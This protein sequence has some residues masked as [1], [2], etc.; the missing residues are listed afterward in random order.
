MKMKKFAAAAM[1]LAL[2]GGSAP[3]IGEFSPSSSLIASAADT[4]YVDLY[5]SL[6]TVSATRATAYTCDK[7]AT[8]NMS[9]RTYYQGIVFDV[10]YSGQKS[11]ITFDV[12]G[13]NTLSW[14]NGHIDGSNKEN[15][16]LKVYVDDNLEDS[17]QLTWTMIA[18]K[19][20]LD[21]SKA[22]KVTL[23]LD[24]CSSCKYGIGDVTTDTDSPSITSAKVDYKNVS[25][26]IA[27]YFDSKNITAYQG[28][29]KSEGFNMNGRTYYQGYYLDGPYSGNDATLSL[30]VE[31]LSKV[32]WTVGHI[33]NTDRGSAKLNVYVDDELTES[34]KLT[35][36]MEL[37][38]CEITLP[39]DAKEM[40]IELAVDQSGEYGIGDIKADALDA[41]V[42]HT[43]PDF[44][45]SSTFVDSGYDI[46][47]A[48]KYT[49]SAKGTNY[50]VNGR[51]Y[52]QGIVF[53]APYSNY[54]TT[55]SY[56]VENLS[57][58][59]FTVGRVANSGASSA[60]L[61]IYIDNVEFD[62][63]A[64]S[65]YMTILPYE[66]KVADAKNVRFS[67]TANGECAY[68]LME[69]TADALAPELIYTSP[70]YAK[71]NNLTDSFFNTSGY[72]AYA[73]NTKADSFNMN[74]RTYYEGIVFE[75]SYSGYNSGASVNVENVD[76]FSF[77]L[78]HVDGTG[79]SAANLNVYL[80]DE[81]IDKIALKGGMILDDKSYD[82]SKGTVL[83]FEVTDRKGGCSYALGDIKADDKETA[84]AHVV[85]KY[86]D[87]KSFIEA[88]FDTYAVKTFNGSSPKVNFFTMGGVDY[89]TGLVFDSSASNYT[90]YISFNV[91]NTDALSFL[92]GYVDDSKR[93]GYKCGATV[94]IYKD[95]ELYQTVKLGEESAPEV[96]NIDTKDAQYIE[97]EVNYDGYGQF[98]VGNISFTEGVPS[99]TTTTTSGTTE[100]TTTTTTTK[101]ADS[102][103]AGRLFGDING[104][105]I[106]DGRD[107]TEMLT[108]YAKTSTGYKGTIEDYMRELAN[109]SAGASSTPAATSAPSTTTTAKATEAPKAT[110]NSETTTA[111]ATTVTKAASTTAKAAATTTKAAATATA[112]AV[113]VTTVAK[114]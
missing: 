36:T 61:H 104:D 92:M 90:N 2:V 108:F 6:K 72:K 102:V 112:K 75:G 70:T 16:K 93:Q 106:L 12:S 43:V 85:P 23:V 111:K 41:G 53:K 66:L 29:N 67:L 60:T 35:W 62:Q 39:K 4:T 58:L 78:G 82:V 110:S 22:S 54:E 21:V 38:Q 52:Y 91:E 49:G 80:D 56:N 46:T 114:G 7:T 64:L 101:S 20:D 50:N 99:A 95:N 25:G 87:A 86:A 1:A 71:I 11:E 14:V 13:V 94:N 68:A 28:S 73:G 31:G 98:G 51:T 83:R 5:P 27:S 57:A 18:Y 74:G 48:D 32:S 40:R 81:L 88:G 26:M 24:E 100:S 63:I 17:I 42:E 3:L 9:G 15:A 103:T 44:S 96:Y 77:T 89:S 8:F 10:P 47:K 105:G 84:N 34:K 55:I 107:A 79:T 109:E 97:F 33:D 65:P 45:K 59:N 76:K 19:Y 69:I 37:E 30:N 113:T